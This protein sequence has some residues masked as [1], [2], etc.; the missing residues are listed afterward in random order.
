VQDGLR[1]GNKFFFG[2][3]LMPY[4]I[5]D[6]NIKAMIDAAKEFGRL[7]YPGR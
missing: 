7:P 6:A 5:P 3:V 1:E 2:T 4:G